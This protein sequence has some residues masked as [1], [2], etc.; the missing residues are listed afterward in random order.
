MRGDSNL[1]ALNQ[2]SRP[3]APRRSLRLHHLL[4][5]AMAAI[6]SAC[7][8]GPDFKIP[9]APEVPLTP[10]PLTTP[11]SAAGETQRFV[12]QLDIPGAWW[13][14][15][16]SRDLDALIERAL[17][18]NYD[19][20][21]PRPH[22][23]SRTPMS[24]PS[25]ARSFRRWLATT[26]QLGRR[27]QP[28]TLPRRPSRQPILLPPYGRIDHFLRARRVR[29]QP[30][31]GR[32]PGGSSRVPAPPA[33]GDLPDP[34]IE[35]CAGRRPGSIRARSNRGHAENHQESKDNC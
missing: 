19:L 9:E 30:A 8:V 10:K 31:A 29:A 7:A 12:H 22:Y 18:E 13:M 15:F 21:L 17:R 28:E 6:L 1:A 25:A 23:A 5:P 32:I 24:R 34:D 4:V 35:H 26:R 27:W 11:G 16:R 3:P 20:K 33:R 2:N 14:L